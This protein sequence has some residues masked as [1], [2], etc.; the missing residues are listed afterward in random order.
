M[1]VCLCQGVSDRD[2][3]TAIDDGA[4]CVG[5]LESRGIGGDCR[6]CEFALECMIDEA[7]RAGRIQRCQA[8]CADAALAYA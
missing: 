5:Q 4:T 6:G 2:V 7:A 3:R 8:C 1:I